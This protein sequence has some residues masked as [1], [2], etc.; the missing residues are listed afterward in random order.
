MLHTRTFE[1]EAT[2]A[3]AGGRQIEASLSSEAPVFRPG[4]GN[5]ILRH[6]ADAIDLT[7]SPLPLIT[8]HDSGN[9]PVGVVESIRLVGTK[10]RGIL[11]FTDGARADELWADVKAGILRNLSIGYQILDGH[12]EGTNYIVSRWQPL[13]ISLVSV[14]ADATVGIGRSFPKE[15]IMSANLENQDDTSE[16]LSRSQRRSSNRS[17]DEAREIA[18]MGQ[19]HA[20]RGGVDLANRFIREGKTVDQFRDALL[21]EAAREST[22]TDTINWNQGKPANDYSL[23]RA[24]D[25]SITNDWAKAGY[26]REMSQEM[27]RAYGRKPRGVYVPFGAMNNTRVMSAGGAT[28]GQTLVPNIH[29]GFIEMVRNNARVLEAGA[30]VMPGLV[31]NI[32]IPRQTAGATAEWLAEDAA[33]TPSDMNFDSVLLTAKSCGALLSWTRR[34]THSSVPEMEGLAR[35]DLAKQIGLAMDRAAV[36]GLGSSDQPTGV[37]AAANVNSVAMGGK[38][39]Y[40]KLID[41]A[42]QLGEDNAL[43][44]NL[45]FLTTPGMAGMLAQT[46]VAS[47]AG[48]DMIW[49]GSMVQGKLIGINAYSTAQVSSTLGAGAEH[50][51]VLGDFSQMIIGVWGGGVDILVDPYSDSDRGRVRISAFMDL[52]IALRHPEAFCKATGA[53]IV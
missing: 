28:T 26:E 6:T 2:R 46:L 12:S 51:L 53:T 30:T 41:M 48:S 1:L 45:A 9:M 15:Q 43:A 36:H 10:L 17:G 21:N 24:I 52:D 8:A 22:Q 33:I 19:A 4:L 47:S 42:T 31:G 38:P 7:R 5:E 3:Q 14:P 20:N 18:A 16:T 50:G 23:L 39:T 37:Y 44:G 40:A 11:R 32:D 35:A 34:M 49:G 25:A 27:A 29:S 13:E